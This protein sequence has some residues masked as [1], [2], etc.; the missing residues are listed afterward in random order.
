MIRC[1]HRDVSEYR[2]SVSTL[3]LAWCRDCGATRTCFRAGLWTRWRQPRLASSGALRV[4]GAMA[5]GVA[6]DAGRDAIR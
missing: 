5:G 1:Q 2:L 3:L 6:A 4:Q